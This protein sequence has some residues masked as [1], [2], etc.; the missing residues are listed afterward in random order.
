[1]ENCKTYFDMC[2]P[3]N[4]RLVENQPMALAMHEISATSNF[5][6]AMAYVPMQGWSQ[7]YEPSVAL[8]Q[9]TIFPELDMPFLG[10]RCCK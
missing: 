7:T 5:P 2:Y 8:R 6:L 10:W 3:Q 9:G 4:M 1:M